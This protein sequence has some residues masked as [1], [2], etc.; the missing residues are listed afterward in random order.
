MDLCPLAKTAIR[1]LHAAIGTPTRL[2][3]HGYHPSV[4]YVEST[5]RL[6]EVELAAGQLTDYARE[7]IRTLADY[8]RTHRLFVVI[9][10]LSKEQFRECWVGIESDEVG[11][12]LYVYAFP[13]ESTGHWLVTFRLMARPE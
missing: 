6:T 8:V 9:R 5:C 1:Q 3:D 11:L 4:R 7:A 2:E 10:L 13:Y 12:A